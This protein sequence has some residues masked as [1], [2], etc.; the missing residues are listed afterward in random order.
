M[1]LRLCLVKKDNAILLT[2]YKDAFVNK[3][4][5]SVYMSHCTL[6]RLIVFFPPLNM[7]FITKANQKKIQIKIHNLGTIFSIF[8]SITD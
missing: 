7:C 5:V 2:F 1:L 4:I 6:P 8:W 3:R